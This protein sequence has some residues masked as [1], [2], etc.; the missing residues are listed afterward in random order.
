MFSLRANAYFC[1]LPLMSLTS[2]AIF[3]KLFFDSSSSMQVEL[4]FLWRVVV[5]LFHSGVGLG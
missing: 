5:L 2:F 3:L 1:I 4:A